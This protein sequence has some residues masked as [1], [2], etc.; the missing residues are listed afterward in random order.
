MEKI[1]VELGENSY[2]IRLGYDI[3]TDCV[4]RLR[5]TAYEREV[6]VVSDR[7]VYEIH[8]GRL[9]TVLKNNGFAVAKYIIPAGESSKSWDMANE[10]LKIMLK[11]NY[12]RKTCV[13]ALGGGVV[14]DLTGFVAAVYRRGVPFIQIPTSLL[15]QVDSSVGGKVAVNHPLGKNMIGS[16]YQPKAVWAELGM[17]ESLPEGEWQ[18]GLA[19]VVKYAIIWD[20]EF[21]D[22]LEKNS[23]R[24]FRRER[25]VLPKMIA[26]C[27]EIKGEVV[28]RDEKDEDLRNILNFGHTFGHALETATGYKKYRH[29]E[30]VAVGMVGAMHLACGLGL[31]S[32]EELQRVEKLLKKW[33]LPMSFSGHLK[34]EVLHLIEHDKKVIGNQV[35]FVLPTEIGSVVLKKGIKQKLIAEALEK[36]AE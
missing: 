28:K 11:K 16:F 12:S 27:C 25:E 9:E 1:K 14:G 24:V 10:I 2:D 18:A 26:V 5:E 7:N 36:I 23:E 34:E 35:T 6:F 22:F 21:F 31:F 32:L 29:G 13:L 8:G 15:A 33:H 20:K 19:E 17:L 30:A 3:L 4:E